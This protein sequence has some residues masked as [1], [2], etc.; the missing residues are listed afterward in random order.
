MAETV[1]GRGAKGWFGW[2][3]SPAQ[4]QRVQEWLAA[5]D[6]ATQT[7]IAKEIATDALQDVGTIPLG[8]FFIRTVYN[9]RITGLLQGPC[10]YPW[11]VRP[12]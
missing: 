5:P 2:W 3:S 6:E 8:Q 4:E 7:R 10:P 11:N 1:R 12:A 9:K